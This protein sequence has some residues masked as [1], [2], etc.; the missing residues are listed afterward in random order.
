MVNP[1]FSLYWK[2]HLRIKATA[3]AVVYSLRPLCAALHLGPEPDIVS[4]IIK[5][6]SETLLMI[7]QFHLVFHLLGWSLWKNQEHYPEENK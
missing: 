5:R 1:E 2:Y 3:K 4:G 6:C 7:F